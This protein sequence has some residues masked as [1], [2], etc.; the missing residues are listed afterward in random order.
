MTNENDVTLEKCKICWK[1]RDCHAVTLRRPKTTGMIRLYIFGPG[2]TKCSHLPPRVRN[3]ANIHIC[4]PD[5]LILIHLFSAWLR[6]AVA[7][8]SE[9]PTRRSRFPP[10]CIQKYSSDNHINS[11]TVSR[12]LWLQFINTDIVIPFS[13]N[14]DDTLP[15]G[16]GKTL[17]S[18]WVISD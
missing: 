18:D 5:P 9:L 8:D 7:L 14:A 17:G 2:A 3:F 6:R 16:V 15:A 13:V 4:S 1:L 11:I 10:S 12:L